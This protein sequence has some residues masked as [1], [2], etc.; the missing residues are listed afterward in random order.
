MTLDEYKIKHQVGLRMGG[1]D[2][3]PDLDKYLRQGPRPDSYQLTVAGLKHVIE[4][5]T[6][7]AFVEHIRKLYHAATLPNPELIDVA[8]N[9]SWPLGTVSYRRECMV[10]YEPIKPNS[11][12]LP[13][14]LQKG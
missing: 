1:L 14:I 5:G 6:N 11:Y 7:P 3:V 4:H 12:R 13:G 2:T 9:I 10:E 8:Y